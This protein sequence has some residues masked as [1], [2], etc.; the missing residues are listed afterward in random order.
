MRVPTQ[1]AN[2]PY[3]FGIWIGGIFIG[4]IGKVWANKRSSLRIGNKRWG[5]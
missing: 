3:K 4:V 1:E 5:N 2:V